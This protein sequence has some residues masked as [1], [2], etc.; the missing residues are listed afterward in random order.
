LKKKRSCHPEHARGTPFVAIGEALKKLEVA[1]EKSADLVGRRTGKHPQQ[2]SAGLRSNLVAGRTC[3][4][5]DNKTHLGNKRVHTARAAVDRLVD[6]TAL[7]ERHRR[8]VERLEPRKDARR[9][10]E[11]LETTPPD[12]LLKKCPSLIGL[13][14]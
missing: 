3:N 10:V 5:I 9:R 12:E 2:K 1:I 7:R 8:E 11:E 14:K 6:R 13:K 4:H